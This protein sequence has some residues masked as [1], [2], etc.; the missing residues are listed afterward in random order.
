MYFFGSRVG[1]D[2]VTFI[3]CEVFSLVIVKFDSS[4]RVYCLPLFICAAAAARVSSF[5]LL[6]RVARL[7][8]FSV[9]VFVSVSVFF[10]FFPLFAATRPKFYL[11]VCL[12]R[13]AVRFRARIETRAD[14]RRTDG[15]GSRSRIDKRR[16]R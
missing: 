1:L 8:L 6:S 13:G 7:F 5:C 14:R 10:S 2:I 4:S 3:S 16:S 11:Y 9:C 15:L 12:D